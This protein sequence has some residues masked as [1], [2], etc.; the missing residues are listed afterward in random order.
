MTR[1]LKTALLLLLAIFGSHTAISAD[2]EV[3]QAIESFIS[4]HN[5][6]HAVYEFRKGAKH[7]V[8]SGAHGYFSLKEQIP[9]RASDELLIASGTKN[10]IAAAIL[11]LEEK[12]L[13]KTSDTIADIFPE[14]SSIWCVDNNK[15]SA[16]PQWANEVT[17]HHL[18]THTS[19]IKEYVFNIKIDPTKPHEEINKQIIHFAAQHQLAFTPGEKYDYNNTGYV[20][21]GMIIEKLT[22]K[23]L[24]LHLREEFFEPLGMHKTHMASLQEV[25][26]YRKGEIKHYPELY[27]AH[28]VGDKFT[29]SRAETSFFFVPYADGGVISTAHDIAT[30]H[31]NLHNGK[32]LGSTAYKKMIKPYIAAPELYMPNRHYGYGIFINNPN[33]KD[34]VYYHSGKAAGVRSE[35]GYIPSKKFSFA[36]ISNVMPM[37]DAKQMGKLDMKD[38]RNQLDIYFF[39]DY[40]LNSINVNY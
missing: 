7:V 9:L 33:S 8:A 26:D 16:F 19:G 14:A 20:I 40:V 37:L 21:L 30:W 34:V 23:N 39:L 22:Q 4:S 38:A 31:Y 1:F 2:K 18:L 3:R 27:F 13:L 25:V 24:A 29:L 17:I 11:K 36:I 15:S 28:F 12:K 6:L 32:V 5:D 10:I 35:T